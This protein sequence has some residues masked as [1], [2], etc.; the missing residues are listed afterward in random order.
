[1]SAFMLLT[2]F[3]CDL[4]RLDGDT[5]SAGAECPTGRAL[6]ADDLPCV[7]AG[8]RVIVLEYA[9][10]VCGDEGVSCEDG[11]TDTGMWPT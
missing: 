7:C 10:C 5:G 11:S 6:T 2:L 8:E 9:N 1:M 3:A 4:W